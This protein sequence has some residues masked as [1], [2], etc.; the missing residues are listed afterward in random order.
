MK[1]KKRCVVIGASGQL[2]RAL[3]EVFKSGSDDEVLETG[4][5]RPPENEIYLDLAEKDSI[6]EAF[7]HLTPD[8]IFIAGAYVNVDRCEKE[9][10]VCYRV[11]AEGPREIASFTQTTGGFVVYYSTDHV[12]PG[13]DHSF[14]ESD[15]VSPLN[16]YS[17]SKVEG[18]KAVRE[19]LPDR[20]LILRTSWLYGPDLKERN[21]PLRLSKDLA[22]G[23]RISV[24]VDQWGSPTFTEDLARATLFLIQKKQTGTFHVRGPDFINRYAYA[25][26]IASQ[27]G[28]SEAQVIPTPTES[29]GQIARRPLRVELEDGKLRSL[30]GPPMRDIEKGLSALKAWSHTLE[31]AP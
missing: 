21:F 11:N 23:E 22:R 14:S 7:V 3:V 15:P 17:K 9:P 19:L 25:C 2:G 24:P 8:F 10:L 16:V 31:V 5:R 12:F 20:H 29:L 1:P 4:R 28:F 27:F 30:G 26:R 13:G 18:E 6:R